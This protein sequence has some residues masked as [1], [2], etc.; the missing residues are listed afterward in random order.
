M[1]LIGDVDCNGIVQSTDALGILRHVADLS[2]DLPCMNV[3]DT[4]CDGDIDA[5]DGLNV[6]R[7]IAGMAVTSPAGCPPVGTPRIP[8]WQGPEELGSSR[9]S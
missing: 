6:L 3:A 4:D 8:A 7:Y 2:P 9:S 5:V 1:V